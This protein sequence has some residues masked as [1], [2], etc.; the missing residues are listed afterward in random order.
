L[1]S[2]FFYGWR[3]VKMGNCGNIGVGAFLSCILLF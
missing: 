3:E 1:E 2:G